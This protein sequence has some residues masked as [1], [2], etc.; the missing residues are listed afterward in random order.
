MGKTTQFRLS[1]GTV[2]TITR[3]EAERTNRAEGRKRLNGTQL[4]NV[5]G[6]IVAKRL[7]DRCSAELESI[8]KECGS[9]KDYRAGVRFMQ[10]AIHK[11]TPKINIEQVAQ[12]ANNTANC[13]TTLS[14]DKTMLPKTYVGMELRD[15]V[16]IADQALNYCAITCQCD[17]LQSRDC[18]LRK[19]FDNIPGLKD[20]DQGG[21]HLNDNE[22][23]YKMQSASTSTLDDIQEL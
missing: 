19:A 7:G 2:K 15:I 11:T 12:M 5:I 16:A 23:P 9:W 22:C 4:D 3:E 20:N 8:M 6:L 10:S 18:L 21:W 13:V 1:N 17:A 14:T